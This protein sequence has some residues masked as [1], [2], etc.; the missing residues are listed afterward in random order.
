MMAGYQE[1][2]DIDLISFIDEDKTAHV[3]EIR[4]ARVA[5]CIRKQLS[6]EFRFK[7]ELGI[8]FHR[9][10]LLAFLYLT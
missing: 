1:V 3:I 8:V 9:G 7:T 10:S 4:A 5:S 2:V 6:T